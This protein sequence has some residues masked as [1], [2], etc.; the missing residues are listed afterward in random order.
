MATD[1]VDFELRWAELIAKCWADDALRARLVAHPVDVLKE[2]GIVVPPGVRL[3]VYENTDTLTN[4]VIPTKPEPV[5]VTRHQL[6]SANIPFAARDAAR[7]EGAG[8]SNFTGGCR[9]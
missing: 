7:C 8:R 2:H 4:L 1:S 3:A 5:E 9:F 6:N